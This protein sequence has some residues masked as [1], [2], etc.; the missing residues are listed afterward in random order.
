MPHMKGLHLLAEMRAINPRQHFILCTG[1][2]DSASEQVA[3]DAGVDGYF[4]KPAP[5]G[6]LAAAIRALC[7]KV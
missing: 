7:A 4:L 5:I 1:F 2:S 6:Q 3:R